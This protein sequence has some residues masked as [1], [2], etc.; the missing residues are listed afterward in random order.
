[1]PIHDYSHIPLSPTKSFVERPALSSKLADS[2][3]SDSESD[4]AEPTLVVVHGLGGAGKSQLVLD[5]VRKHREHYTATFWIE[6]GNI[7]SI[8][9]DFHQT[10]RIM[11]NLQ[12]V[13]SD[14]LPNLEEVIASV[15]SWVLRRDGKWLVVLDE[16]DSLFEE[17]NS[18]A[19]DFHTWLPATRNVH[20]IMT[21]R[22]SRAADLTTLAAIEVGCMDKDEASAL[23]KA[24]AGVVT[25]QH[26]HHIYE[27]VKELGFF[28]L[29]ISLAGYYIKQT[30]WLYS[31]LTRY[32]PQY[33]QQRREILGEKP[34]QAVHHYRESVLTTWETSFSAVHVR[35]PSAANLFLLVCWLNPND[36]FEELFNGVMMPTHDMHLED[37]E[38]LDHFKSILWLGREG[39]DMHS[40]SSCFRYLQEYSLVRWEPTQCR[41]WIHTLF[42][43][44]AQDRLDSETKKDFITLAAKILI[45]GIYLT[46]WKWPL[47]ERLMSQLNHMCHIIFE[48]ISQ[49]PDKQGTVCA[50]LLTCLHSI[51]DFFHDI[52]RY[53][54]LK[55]VRSFEAEFLH[56]AY[57]EFDHR[58]LKARSILAGSFLLCGYLRPAR[59]LYEKVHHLQSQVLG[60]EHCDSVHT[61]TG[62]A[63]AYCIGGDRAMAVKLQGMVLK[64]WQNR[65]E[66]CR[67]EVLKA[68]RTLA[69][70]LKT[71]G[72]LDGATALSEEI[73]IAQ[74]QLHD[75]DDRRLLDALADR[76]K[77]YTYAGCFET[78]YSISMEV[79]ARRQSLLG[80][81]HSKTLIAMS[82][83]ATNLGGMG[84]VAEE[85][86]M[87]L[88]VF[89]RAKKACGVTHVAT[90]R[91]LTKLAK[92]LSC[93]GNHEHAL[94]MQA[95]CLVL[96]HQS[97][98]EMQHKYFYRQGVLT[99]ALQGHGDYRWAAEM[100]QEA[101]CRV[102][103]I[104]NTDYAVLLNIL[105]GQVSQLYAR[106][107]RLAAIAFAGEFQ[108]LMI[109]EWGGG[110]SRTLFASHRLILLLKGEKKW[111]PAQPIQG[112]VL[113]KLSKLLGQYHPGTTG[114]KF[115]LAL[116]L[117][118][119]RR[120]V[121]A[122]SL[123]REIVSNCIDHDPMRWASLMMHVL[124]L[125]LVARNAVEEGFGLHWKAAA[126]KEYEPWI[127]HSGRPSSCQE[128]V[129]NII[130]DNHFE[131]A[132]D[133]IYKINTK[134]E[135]V[136]GPNDFRTLQV[137]RW[138]A[139]ILTSR[140]NSSA[141]SEKSSGLSIR[142]QRIIIYSSTGQ[143]M[144]I[145]RWRLRPFLRRRVI[146]RPP[147]SQSGQWEEVS[148]GPWE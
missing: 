86:K 124:A 148:T 117:G 70:Y 38:T 19:S 63:W 29:A 33:R 89:Q 102:C 127:D 73:L 140:E 96:S 39:I 14:K 51:G 97:Q 78:A 62:T 106:G 4:A 55:T 9:R 120:L 7:Q 54:L 20:V 71:S 47:Q 139:D 141:S 15:K 113:G 6:A 68:Q 26:D 12:G 44:W 94:P 132:E 76:A 125:I 95:V 25:N 1:M 119:V 16:M 147:R 128:I 99:D 56:S 27:I 22:D 100:I 103:S 111:V 138:L 66:E 58:C 31:D 84:R 42:Q 23:F 108:N 137:R 131:A 69:Y 110:H 134:C 43:A 74:S 21:T 40:V 80:S 107:D 129:R 2:L 64:I 61:L 93:A 122:E 146:V 75:I 85:E 57:G 144:K 145:S 52:G 92:C 88:T 87:R 81:L 36:L 79:M 65:H 35:S 118:K 105:D 130:R 91:Y 28:A 135:Q 123:M 116:I 82:W 90:L 46:S 34:L 83:V 114:A 115:T 104:R 48:R 98:D 67:E 18:R 112:R 133:Y 24:C 45:W 109:R 32:L 121:E 3:S 11:Y 126:M 136:L 8:E 142:P 72:D 101:Y 49:V 143:P 53:A 37:V 77:Y 50:D 59:D 30:P 13:L 17:E 41:Y 5:H 10:Y 60:E